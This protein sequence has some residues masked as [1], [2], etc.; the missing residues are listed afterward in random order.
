M[1][2]LFEIKSFH[3]S[4]YF[5]DNFLHLVFNTVFLLICFL[6]C[7]KSDEAFFMI[8]IYIFGL[9][10]PFLLFQLIYHFFFFRCTFSF[11]F[12]IVYYSLNLLRN[13]NINSKCLLSLAVYSRRP[14]KMCTE[15]KSVSLFWQT[16]SQG[17]ISN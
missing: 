9:L 14:Q 16:M 17:E 10:S 12:P 4:V 3:S 8:I 15:W 2:N 6:Y 13:Y 7:L 1:S 11:Y 5:F